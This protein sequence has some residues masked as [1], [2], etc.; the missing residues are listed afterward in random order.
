MLE[1]QSQSGTTMMTETEIKRLTL[2]RQF[3]HRVA[4]FISRQIDSSHPFRSELSLYRWIVSASDRRTHYLS[5]PP[6]NPTGHM[7][8]RW[9]LAGVL[10]HPRTHLFVMLIVLIDSLFMANGLSNHETSTSKAIFVV[11]S[12]IYSCEV[13]LKVFAFGSLY[14]SDPWDLFDFALVIGSLS[15]FAMQKLG[16]VRDAALLT[17]LPV[18]RLMRALRTAPSFLHAFP[19]VK[20]LLLAYFCSLRSIFWIAMLLVIQMYLCSIIECSFGMLEIAENGPRQVRGRRTSASEC[21]CRK[22]PSY[23]F[24]TIS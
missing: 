22:K 23:V 17:L 1:R 5:H 10:H 14:F 6:E 7:M 21:R 3:S 4:T 13:F 15:G 20:T 16:S 24:V 9:K 18:F 19:E 12:V 8:L 11:C 2:Q